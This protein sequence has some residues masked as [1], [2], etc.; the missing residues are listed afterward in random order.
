MGECINVEYLAYFQQCL[1]NFPKAD[2]LKIRDFV[3]HL[4]IM[5]LMVWKG[6]IIHLTMFP[7]MTHNG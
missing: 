2:Q 1:K 6:V 3:E 7:K 5:D 4:K